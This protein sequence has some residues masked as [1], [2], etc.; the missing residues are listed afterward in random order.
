M[1]DFF[2]NLIGSAISTAVTTGTKALVANALIDDKKVQ[3]I[4]AGNLG[5]KPEQQKTTDQLLKSVLDDADIKS[6]FLGEVPSVGGILTR[7]AGR[8]DPAVSTRTN[9]NE[10]ARML[11]AL[12]S[13]E[14]AK[15]EIF[16]DLAGQIKAPRINMASSSRRQKQS[17]RKLLKG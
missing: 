2:S 15:P 4:G 14:V 11:I 17:I 12:K 1:S 6:G 3:V 16:D 10:L 7:Q 13:P 5:A 9:Q 8:A